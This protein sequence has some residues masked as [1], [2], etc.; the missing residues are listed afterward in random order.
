MSHPISPISHIFI[1]SL[2]FR[3]GFHYNHNGELKQVCLPWG[4]HTP[5]Y[6]TRP[7]TPPLTP[8]TYPHHLLRPLTPHPT[9]H[10]A[11]SPNPTP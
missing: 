6:A 7:G 5:L 2:E 1:Q 9:P 11:R 10:P 3:V 8:T 4:H